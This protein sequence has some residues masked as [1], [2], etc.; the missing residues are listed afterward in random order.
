MLSGV[1]VI[2]R[3]REE[4]RMADQRSFLGTL[5]A[6]ALG[7]VITLLVAEGITRLFYQPAPARIQGLALKFSDYYQ[8]DPELGWLPRANVFGTQPRFPATSFK[9]NSKGLR[10]REYDEEKTAGV[11]RIVVVGDSQQHQEPAADLPGHFAFHGNARL[12]DALND[13]PHG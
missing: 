11:T 1:D 5:V 9:T 2:G 12:G 8:Q 4:V 10:D 7:M 6:L 3:K 13:C